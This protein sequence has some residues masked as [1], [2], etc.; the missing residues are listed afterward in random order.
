MRVFTV[1]FVALLC[2]FAFGGTR[3]LGQEKD[4]P[5]DEPAEPKFSFSEF[6]KASLIPD[7]IALTMTE[8]PATSISVT[9]RT[10]KLD[11][12]PVAEIALATG[13]PEFLNAITTAKVTTQKLEFR[14][15]DSYYHTATFTGLKPDT[16]YL[17]RVG[18]KNKTSE[19]NE[20][21]TA[22][23]SDDRF[24]FVYFGDAQNAIKAMWSRVS[25]RGLRD[26]PNASF[27]LHAG[28]LV[29]TAD[30][31]SEWG[32]WFYAG[33]WINRSI[34]IVATPGNHEYG[35]N[36][37]S[38]H[39][40]PNF[41]FPL[42][43]PKGLEETAYYFDYQGTRFI[44]LNSSREIE[45]QIEWLDKVLTGNKSNWTILTSHHPFYSPAASRDNPKMRELFAPLFEKHRIDLCL[46]GHDH[47]YTRTFQTKLAKTYEESPGAR[48]VLNG[49]V[50]A[51]SVS[52]PKMYQ[53]KKRNVM[54]RVAEGTQLYQL[55]TVEKNRIHYQAKTA[56]GEL[57]DEFELH[58]NGEKVEIKDMTPKTPERRFP[59]EEKKEETKKDGEKK[60]EEAKKAAS[61]PLQKS[62]GPLQLPA[63]LSGDSHAA[64]RFHCYDWNRSYPNVGWPCDAPVLNA[65]FIAEAI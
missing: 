21:K 15:A 20:F 35:S 16:T 60:K 43:G 47:S 45:K 14:I 57:Y 39:W 22:K 33:G 62:S 56:A 12:E 51:V 41:E 10:S 2:L 46:Q 31:D 11:K 28:D 49:T 4:K 17:Y 27:F 52:G 58:R 25:R 50:F 48:H 18:S 6:H 13:G 65:K 63:R 32:E 44:S 8:D 30:S 42:N 61:K 5:K 9:W 38:R 36:G 23:K 26:M 24:S 40:R 59:K 53:A 19:W 54:Q 64:A 55:V 34:P 37:L 29:N 1:C 7:R 3:S